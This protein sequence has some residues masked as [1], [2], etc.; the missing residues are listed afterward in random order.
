M[1]CSHT[2][3]DAPQRRLLPPPAAPNAQRVLLHPPTPHSTLQVTLL[4][5]TLPSGASF[6]HTLPPTHNA[7]SYVLTGGPVAFGETEAEG[8]SVSPP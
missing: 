6:S 3:H 2:F 7:F 8:E 1:C 5:V 4:D